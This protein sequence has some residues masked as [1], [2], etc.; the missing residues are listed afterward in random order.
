MSFTG[1]AVPDPPPASPD[2]LSTTARACDTLHL[3]TPFSLQFA[4]VGH[5]SSAGPP[6][7]RFHAHRT[8]GRHRHREFLIA[9][10]LPAV[11]KIQGHDG[12]PCRCPKQPEAT[13]PRPAQLREPTR[14]SRRTSSPSATNVVCYTWGCRSC[15]ISNERRSSAST[16]PPPCSRRRQRRR[17]L[18]P[19]ENDDLP[20]VA[21]QRQRLPVRFTQERG[22][23]R[24][25][26]GAGQQRRRRI[27]P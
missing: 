10:L 16:T 14:I 13:R 25:A 26:G 1:D 7:E 21:G 4:E 17:D 12:Q 23:R 5:G 2:F 11:Q 20:L 9:L 24:F 27:T 3:L 8:V 15:R 18:Q 19:L 22:L 6:Y